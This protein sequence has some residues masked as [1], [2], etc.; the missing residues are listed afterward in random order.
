VF[1]LRADDGRLVWWFDLFTEGTCRPSADGPPVR[2]FDGFHTAEQLGLPDDFLTTQPGCNFD[3]TVTG[4]GNV[5]S[6][7]A[8]DVRR[9][10]IY[11][12]SGNCDTDDDPTTPD[13]PPPLPRYEEAIFAIT[14]NGDPV[15]AWRPRDVDPNDLDFGAVPNL[16]EATI[17]GQVRDLI[18]VGGKDGTYYVLDR[19]GVNA[20]TGMLE[21]YWRTNVVPGG[22]AGGF[23]GAASVGDGLIVGAT[24][25]GFDPSHPQL[26]TV[27][28]FDPA[29]G[30]V[31][32]EYSDVD[33]D[34]A[35]TMGVPGLA[36][37]GSTP[38][39]NLNFFTRDGGQLVRA[40]SASTVPGGVAG[41]AT[42]VGPNL[43]VGGGS[44]AFNSGGEAEDSARR[45]TPLSA[46]CVDGTPGCT[47]NTCDD[48]ERCTYDYRDR[49][50]TCVS[51]PAPDGIDCAISGKLGACQNGT[52]IVTPPPS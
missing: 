14:L 31:V 51:E 48:G 35:P 30:A 17:G 22:T 19:D 18:G 10:M 38:R 1:A 42:L 29:T 52:C 16:F 2:R 21:P 23:I 5:W 40:L 41:G 11:S 27:H 20:M 8:I 25:F 39:A 7:P 9:G 28:A 36:I 15:W 47:A 37:T 34:F 32:W 3:R 44:G 45:D 24:A 6:S 4:C 49:N 50:G 13:P 26:P 12:V 43:Y 46:F 33:G